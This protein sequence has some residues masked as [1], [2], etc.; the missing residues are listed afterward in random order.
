[1]Y[2]YTAIIPV[3]A[4]SKRIKDKNISKFGKINL[5]EN[6]INILKKIKFID[7]IVVSSDS[8]K[9]LEMAKKKMSKFIEE[10]LN[11]AMNKQ[12]LLDQW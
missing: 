7:N 3:R 12:D 1:M 11:I 4:G 9:M 6:K 8:N 5:L 10:Q 2:K